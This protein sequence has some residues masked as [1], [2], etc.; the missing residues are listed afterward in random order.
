MRISRIVVA[1]AVSVF[2]ICSFGVTD[3]YKIVM[4]LKVPQVVR[5]SES[6]GKRIIQRQT[7]RGVMKVRYHDDGPADVTIVGLTNRTFKVSGRPVT[8]T[9]EPL[10]SRW[11]LIGNNANGVFV[12]PSVSAEFV[13]SPS[14]AAG[15]TPTDDNSLVV[16]MAGTGGSV[17]RIY[18]KVTGT[19]GCGCSDYG[20]VS[21]TRVMGAFGPLRIV[22]DVASL[23]GTWSA[24][25]TGRSMK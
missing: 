2:S 20:H 19:V 8:Y 6:T 5:N 11:N 25:R 23:Y 15:F 21:P 3:T 22:D 12:R 24:V 16:S 14:Y 10:S 13:A 18:G 7:L 4:R 17:K 1:F 9:T